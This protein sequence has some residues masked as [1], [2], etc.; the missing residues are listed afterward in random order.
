MQEEKKN[1]KTGIIMSSVTSAVLAVALLNLLDKLG[2][3][4]GNFSVL[5]ILKVA[6]T[7][8]IA[9]GIGWIISIF[10]SEEEIQ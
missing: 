8:L 10:Y 5:L 9:L 3:L 2:Q 1:Y 4:S 7:I 6:F